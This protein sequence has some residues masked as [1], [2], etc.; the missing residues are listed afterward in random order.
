MFRTFLILLFLAACAFVGWYSYN[1]YDRV[2]S[3]VGKISQFLEEKTAVTF[4]LAV[5]GDAIMQSQSHEL[6]KDSNHTFGKAHVKFVP[7]LLLE[8]KY[9][10]DAKNTQEG[11][12][13]WSL[14][15]GEMVLDTKTFQTTHGFQDF[16]MQ[17]AHDDDFYLIHLL[18]KHN[19]TLSKDALFDE[20]ILD[21]D[22][23]EAAL[24]DLKKKQLISIKGH[25]IHLHL[26]NP[27]VKVTPSTNFAHI[28]VTKTINHDDKIA[29]NYS[30]SQVKRVAQAAF[31]HDFA[32]RKEQIIY[33]PVIQIDIKN[34]DGS[35]LKT[36]WNGVTG[37]RME[38]IHFIIP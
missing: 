31:G 28:L 24:A 25:D 35:V 4:E 15:N 11:R 23:I 26:A 16:I 33:L 30:P 32:I 22:R 10:D 9:V 29:P 17:K 13:L 37:K 34:P 1:N 12:L 2:S 19:G 8:V 5:S 18:E 7:L 6:L 21:S 3:E 27:M 14:E 38:M 20:A 36:Y